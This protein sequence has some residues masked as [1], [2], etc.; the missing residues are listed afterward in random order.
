MANDVGIAAV[1]AA[2][3]RLRITAATYT[4]AWGHFAARGVQEKRVLS[5]DED[6]ATLAVEAALPLLHRSGAIPPRSILFG[7]AGAAAA[8]TTLAEA[9]DLPHAFTADLL[10]SETQGLAAL[11]LGF[12]RTAAGNGPALVVAS[13]SLRGAPDDPAEHG[14]GAAAVACIV[15][16]GGTVHLKGQAAVSTEGYGDRF[17]DRDGLWRDPGVGKDAAFRAKVAI[18]GLLRG[19]AA[20]A[21]QVIHL[22]PDVL[23][24]FG[25]VGAVSPLAGL[26]T[27][28]AR[29]TVGE[30]AV[31]AGGSGGGL[32][33]RLDVA[34][35]PDLL[36]A[37]THLG[38]KGA[39]G[40]ASK[41]ITYPA[42]LQHRRLVKGERPNLAQ[43]AFV[44][45]PAYQES[46]PARYRLLAM[47][48]RACNHV[49]FP[50]RPVCPSCS[51][52]DPTP[53]WLSRRATVYAITTI[54]RGGA[55]SEFAEQQ[56]LVGEYAVAIVEFPEGPRLSVQL[57]DVEPGPGGVA[58][59]Q[60]V[61]AV[62]RRI[63]EQEGIVRYG[64]KFRPAPPGG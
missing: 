18:G 1:G 35:V 29:G 45:L 22:H 25:D 51:A 49:A 41:E 27:L 57:T 19:G 52:A 4:K 48:C 59:G 12:D 10:G 6:E 13:D 34:K 50:P 3:P 56:R 38:G 8:A 20:V 33:L 21:Q 5:F 55:P 2:V 7:S 46:V 61:E 11:A 26:A 28:L 37:A 17:E 16:A 9:L 63:F 47:K 14:F 15:A 32:A 39:G 40:H 64:L 42:Y 62:F 58:I 44:P 24:H 43:G 23:A 31:A 53:L 60:P 30:I 36:G 54:G